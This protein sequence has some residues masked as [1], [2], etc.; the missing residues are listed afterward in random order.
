[1][2]VLECGF[3]MY[4]MLGHD[5][6]TRCCSEQRLAEG[7]LVCVDVSQSTCAY[8][9]CVLGKHFKCLGVLPIWQYNLMHVVPRMMVG[10]SQVEV[11]IQLHATFASANNKIITEA[12]PRICKDLIQI[13]LHQTNCHSM[14]GAR[15]L[16]SYPMS[17]KPC[18]KASP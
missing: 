4:T 1:M 5:Y 13:V 2:C 16:E 8:L 14:R 9:I 11:R 7:M 15:D 18:T 12:S 3:W 10:L 6:M 17:T